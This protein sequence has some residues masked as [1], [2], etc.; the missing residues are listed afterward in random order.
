MLQKLYLNPTQLQNPG[1]SHS[2]HYRHGQELRAQ[3]YLLMVSKTQI[4]CFG[5]ITS[6]FQMRKTEVTDSCHVAGLSIMALE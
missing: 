5:M 6:F 1:F 3:C 2:T 4:L